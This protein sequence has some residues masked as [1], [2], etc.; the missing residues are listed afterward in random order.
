MAESI[1]K[2]KKI[3]TET[4]IYMLFVAI[5][6]DVISLIPFANFITLFVGN[7]I[8]LGW[9]YLIGIPFNTKR[10]SSFGISSI[11]ELIPG[12]SMLPAFTFN[13]CFNYF[14]QK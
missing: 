7:L 6:L 2:E 4:F 11:I 8:F 12:I 13:I 5:I 14:T 10:V 1:K 3:N 9:F